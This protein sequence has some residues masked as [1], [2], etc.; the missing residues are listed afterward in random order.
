MSELFGNDTFFWITA[1]IWIFSVLAFRN[2]RLALRCARNQI[3]MN[4]TLII[5]FSAIRLMIGAYDFGQKI[6]KD[7]EQ[8][9][10]DH[11]DKIENHL[12]HGARLERAS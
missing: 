5:S 8:R 6:P 10:R 1:A 9:L 12:Q 7:L 2:A 11:M 4:E 3:R